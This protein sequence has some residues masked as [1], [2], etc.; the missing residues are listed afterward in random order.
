MSDFEAAEK[1]W[2]R[3]IYQGD[4]MPQ[5]TLRAVL[6]G[7]LLGGVMS[8]SNLYV[9]L[10]TGWGLGVAIT[11]CVL[12]FSINRALTSL[13]PRLFRSQMSLLEN[14]CMQSTATC[15]GVSTGGTMISA[16]AAHLL[17]TG[18]HIDY[19]SLTLWTIFLASLGVF[20]AIPMKRQM[21]NREQLPFPSG[22]ATAE[23]LRSLHSDDPASAGKARALAWSGVVGAMIAWLRDAGRP[24][25]IPGMLEF[26]GLLKGLP[27]ARFTIS[28]EMS[29]IMLAG[30]A[31][32][33]W[34][35]AWSMLLGATINYAVLAP[36]CLMRGI[37]SSPQLGYRSIVSLSTWFGSSIM[38]ASALCSLALQG[39]VLLASAQR[40]IRGI[41]G[42]TDGAI[43]PHLAIEVPTSWFVWGTGLSGLGCILL[44]HFRFQTSWWMG[45]LAV[46]LSFVLSVV[47]CRATG[48]TDT[49]P[50]GPMGKI[51]QLTF[52]AI[53]PT[54]MVTNLMTASVTAGAAGASADL[55]SDLKC[56]YLLGANPRRQFIA[57]LL[58]IVAGV[59]VV[60]PAFYL[61]VPDARSLG[62]AQW[63]APAAQVWAAV[64]RLMANGF[65]ALP[66]VARLGLLLGLVVGLVLPLAEYLFPRAAR[67]IPSATG[68]GLAMVIPFYNS[69]SM[70]VG[71]LVALGLRKHSS[72]AAERWVIPV[73]SG[74]IAGE[75]I[76]GVLVA[77]L[78]A[79]HVMN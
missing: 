63:P 16:I 26:P 5:L 3:E 34:K 56:G 2:F 43:E 45:L 75:S 17:I 52:G 73:S 68:L 1:H 44:L 67:F 53:A 28:W 35:V 36:L 25:A 12:S 78:K 41:F 30:G 21:I 70:F 64:A 11:A 66:P 4:R 71:A 57:Q 20:I 15:A 40:G 29:A 49:T 32:M 54:N 22:I 60:V 42:P 51:T 37:L 9:G 69:L 18:R 8:L 10:K 13:L 7:S 76:V 72:S 14:N 33:G 58:G 6:M 48:E 74:I 24:F 39:R 38:V 47:A 31:L 19:W 79:L 59:I 27:L 23:T 55:L 46:A 62:T 77:V 61:L 50:I 65:A